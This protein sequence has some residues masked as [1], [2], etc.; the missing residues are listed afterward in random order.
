MRNT[1]L[2]PLN[3]GLRNESAEWLRWKS[4]SGAGNRRVIS[5]IC[6]SRHF[7]MTATITLSFEAWMAI[8]IFNWAVAYWLGYRHGK[9]KPVVYTSSPTQTTTT[10]TSP[11]L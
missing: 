10:G 7:T 5:V 1:T 11:N 2:P 6:R 3:T 4:C 8:G 9:R